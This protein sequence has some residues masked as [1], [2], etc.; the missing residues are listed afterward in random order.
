MN[1]SAS[2]YRPF[3]CGL[4]ASILFFVGYTAFGWSGWGTPAAVE[5]AVGEVSRW[6]E[7][8]QP[9]LFHEPVN[10][11]SNLGFMVAG[12][13]MLW[14]LGG[15]VRAGRQGL[16]FGHS[17][18]ALLYAGA[19]IWLGPG[20]LLMHGTHTGW[21]GWADNL[22]MVM[23]ILIPWLINV[24]AMGRW[25]SIRLLTIYTALVIIYGIGRAVYGW[26]LGINLDFFGLS[27]AFWVISEVLYRFHSQHFRWISGLVGFAVAGIFG[28]TPLEMW[29]EPA[30][31]WWVVL[32]W[33]ARAYWLRVRQ[34]VVAIIG[35]GSSSEWAVT[36]SRLPFGK[37]GKP[38]HP[39]CNPDSLIQAH[40][41]WHLLSA[42]ATACFFV[43]LRTERK[44]T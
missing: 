42:A 14:R 19:A 26:G 34:W 11:L 31:Y 43:F 21:G 25:T 44:L 18:V 7:R 6:C 36:C 28:I 10:A 29:A 40:G 17:P 8:V 1:T 38:A 9:G 24:G 23:Y 16:M 22:S 41:I 5:Q 4:L 33:R 20:S 12:L 15:D 3:Q 32:F 35:P 37:R 30:R 13:W 39:W 2:A 27:I